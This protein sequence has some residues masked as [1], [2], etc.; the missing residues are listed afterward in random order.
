MCLIVC[1]GEAAGAVRF[2]IRCGGGR[3]LR[4]RPWRADVVGFVVIVLV[5]GALKLQ[6]GCAGR[7]RTDGCNE[8]LDLWT[9]YFVGLFI[10]GCFVIIMDK[11]F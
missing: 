8:F 11:S 6:S 4:D 9:G 1:F 3:K 2:W 5:A 10:K 7:V